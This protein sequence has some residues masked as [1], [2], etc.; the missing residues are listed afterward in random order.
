MKIN[1]ENSSHE[2]RAICECDRILINFLSLSIPQFSNFD[3]NNCARSES[4][5]VDVECCN[6]N[7][8]RKEILPFTVVT[9]NKETSKKENFPLSYTESTKWQIREFR[10]FPYLTSISYEKRKQNSKI[11]HKRSRNIP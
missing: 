6:W 11:S 2:S 4:T 5:K 10:T 9:S 3:E 8:Y 7:T 1:S